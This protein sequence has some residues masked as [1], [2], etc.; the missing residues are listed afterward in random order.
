MNNDK[1][2]PIHVFSSWCKQCGICTAICPKKVLERGPDG[3]PYAARPG[4]CIL[5]GLCEAHCPDFAITLKAKRDVKEEEE[6]E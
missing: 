6:H 1:E 5:C 3:Y 4:D 2:E